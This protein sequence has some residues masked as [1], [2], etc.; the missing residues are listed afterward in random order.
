M[1]IIIVIIL[2]ATW[3]SQATCITNHACYVCLKKQENWRFAW[4]HQPLSQ[5][6]F[7]LLPML[8]AYITYEHLRERPSL[9][10]L[11]LD[12]WNTAVANTVYVQLPCMVCYDYPSVYVHLL[13]S[14]P[15]K[16]WLPW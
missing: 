3:D 2:Q 10:P 9:S 5:A 4:Y 11:V 14:W 1:Y 8:Y 13:A 16:V 7:K 15:T 6:V 12:H